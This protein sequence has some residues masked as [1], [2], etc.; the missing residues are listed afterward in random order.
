MGES[1]ER[2]LEDQA[3]AERYEKFNEAYK[4]SFRNLE[5]S[6]ISQDKAEMQSFLESLRIQRGKYAGAL[7]E[8]V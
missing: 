7:E 8:L 5:E 2:H 3:N 4:N 1:L 6:Q